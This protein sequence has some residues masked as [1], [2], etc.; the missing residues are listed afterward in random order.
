MQKQSKKALEQKQ[1]DDP[2]FLIP[3]S[4][5]MNS[6]DKAIGMPT[7]ES[8]QLIGYPGWAELAKDLVAK[9]PEDMLSEQS[10]KLK[11]HWDNLVASHSPMTPEDAAGRVAPYIIGANAEY[12]AL[13]GLA[14]AAEIM[15]MFQLETPAMMLP[16]APLIRAINSA[17]ERLVL[18]QIDASVGIGYRHY[19]LA[20]HQPVIIPPEILVDAYCKGFI[21]DVAFKGQMM[22]HGYTTERSTII[23]AAGFNMP[24]I[25]TLLN[26][27]RRGILSEKG[28]VD[29]GKYH[30]IPEATL[31][32]VYKL[33]EEKP[34]PYRIADF[35]AKSIIDEDTLSSAFGWY[36]LNKDWAL[37]WRDSQYQFPSVNT[38]IE[39]L[40]RG[41][42][43]DSDAKLWL[44]RSAVPSIAQ[45]ALLS[46]KKQLI[47]VNTLARAATSG[48]IAKQF[49]STYAKQLG[50]E[51]GE[52]G[53][54]TEAAYHYPDFATIIELFWRGFIDEATAKQ[55]LKRLGFTDNV[56][57]ALF[58]LKDSIPSTS[59]LIT[60]VVREAFVPEMVTPAPDIFAKYMAM[61]GFSKE[62]SDRYWTAHWHPIGLEQAYDNVRRGL[63]NED[64]LKNVLKIQDVHPMWWDDIVNV[65]YNPPSIRELGYGWDV[66]V[67]TKDDIKK[68][69]MWGGLS[70]EDADKSSEALVAYRTEAER[71][72]VR[73]ELMYAYAEG[74]I[75]REEFEASLKELPTQQAAVDFWLRRGDLYKERLTWEPPQTESRSITRADA[76]WAFMHGLR[77]ENWL[78]QVLK[79]IGY[80][81][82][83]IEL[84]VAVAKQ[85]LV[86]EQKP[87]EEPQPKRLTLSQIED[88]YALGLLTQDEAI[89]RIMALGYSQAD[90][91]TVWKIISYSP[92]TVAKYRSLSMSEVDALYKYNVWDEDDLFNAYKDMGYSDADAG[93]LVMLA[94]LDDMYPKLKM[95]YEKGYID[96]KELLQRFIDLG[97]SPT[98]AQSVVKRLMFELSMERV[99]EERALTKSEI[100]KGVKN[101]V[102]S[103]EDGMQFLEDLGYSDSEAR[104]ILVIN[105]IVAA[106]DP[107]GYW[108]MRRAVELMKKAQGKPYVEIP[109][110]VV[111]QERMIEEEKQ[112]IEDMKARGAKEEVVAAELGVL[113]QMEAAFRKLLK[114]YL[115]A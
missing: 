22:Y 39:L 113:A 48:I 112:K 76:T 10:D 104:Y 89:N 62:W 106:G 33:A 30:R 42:I 84:Y 78:R 103:F 65:M 51:E 37:K 82:D 16:Q 47:D 115:L 108:E 52:F 98:D 7:S 40:R 92:P 38:I 99:S 95:L 61:R 44:T 32:A 55:L 2:F 1:P 110:E 81:D 90:A 79:S 72:S 77:D 25:G 34:E 59:D 111:A 91:N 87:P 97:L 109:D 94:V 49:A 8:V 114:K 21:D 13:I 107:M 63:K 60:M 14:T 69:R 50:F 26:L 9:T 67:Y 29:W 36:G 93:L 17:S 31:Q 23:G 68:Y 45:D 28:F 100:I 64:W 73:T 27:A 85:K 41:L 75:N 3:S 53:L 11:T 66:G 101:G 20:Q 24:D 35:A 43:R 4:V 74:R 54:I 88:A 83:A 57:A 71:N 96:D 12:G 70:Q 19:T 86:E 80:S 6:H 15:G 18:T 102:F 56:A 5:Y 105:G 58:S 46:L